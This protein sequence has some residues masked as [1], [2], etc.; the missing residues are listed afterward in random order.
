MNKSEE[1]AKNTIIISVGKLFTQFL[2]FVLLPL[3]TAV[4]TTEEYG[5]V[6]LISTYVQLLLP[7]VLLQIDQAL[8]RFIIEDRANSKKN[9]I[10][11]S[12]VIIF[13]LI[14]ISV[15]TIIFSIGN[16]FLDIDFWLYLYVTVV[17]TS[18]SSIFL[19]IARGLGDNISYSLASFFCG[20]STVILNV[21]FLT[22]FHLRTEGM[23][24]SV[25]IGNITTI[26]YLFFKLRVWKYISVRSFDYNVLKKMVLYS[27]PLVPNALIWWIVNASD[28]SIVLFALGA[29]ANGVLAIAHKFPTL[30]TTFYN[31]FHLSW[32]ESAAL[33]LKE[34]D[35]DEFFSS[36]FDTVLRLFSSASIG[37]I[38]V[39]PFLF[40]VFVNNSYSE[41]YY[42]I[43]IYTCASLFNIIVGLY[44]VIYISEMK[45][46]EIAKTSFYSGIIN[47]VINLLLIN[48]I[49]LYAASISSAVAFGIMALY[50]AHD[51]KKYINQRINIKLITQIIIM[52][53]LA[54]ISYYLENTIISIC[55]FIVALINAVVINKDL[56]YKCISK[57]RGA[58]N[59]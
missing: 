46:H 31:F 49:G 44:S 37:L 53:L 22:I 51:I 43:P 14:Q 42:Q 6:D 34:K 1:L 12:S 47:I 48:K 54:G 55:F 15:F 33:H 52:F 32:T 57:V 13:W 28:R 19:Q 50:R 56:I 16:N 30:I 36:V 5:I 26:L 10:Q 35:K 38:A 24:L 18:L 41:A 2:S 7:F 59:R 3:Y 40:P 21:V 58:K 25:I 11:I 29:S 8:L 20:A 45:T 39:M 23:L 4:L 9:S 17:V 27:L